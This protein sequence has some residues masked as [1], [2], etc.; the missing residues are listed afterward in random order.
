M[1]GVSSGDAV[2]VTTEGVAVLS[3]SEASARDVAIEDALRRAVEQ[4]VGTVIT[5]ESMTENYELLSDRIYSKATGHVRKYKILRESKDD[6]LFR[7]KIHA[8]VGTDRIKDDLEAI[9][10]LM[11]RKHKPRVMVIAVETIKDK[12]LRDL[13]NL[14]VTESAMI[15]IFRQKGFKV[16]DADTVKKVTERDQLLSALQGDN[17]LAAKIGLQ[18]GAEI[19]VMGK[20]TADSS[21]YIMSN[22]KLQSINANVTARVIRTDNAEIIATG[23]QMSTRAHISVISGAHTAFKIAGEK[24]AGTMVEQIL[25]KWTT[26][27]ANLNSVVL[28]I[29]GLDSYS[30]LI[31][32]KEALAHDVRGVKGVH[33]RS[34][35]GGEAKLEIELRGDTQALAEVLV[36]QEIGNLSIDITDMSQ[37]KIQ[38]R[39]ME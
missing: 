1:C 2:E 5:S 34:F 8:T 10:L 25:G 18:Y 24:L 6:G 11:Q 22:N 36:T 13:G 28:V 7:V 35:T 23:D 33:Q 3:S 4:A 27:T 16:I 29:S 12:Y 37:N 20:A 21:G 9:G 39:I 30:D 14:S 26:E 38:A 15:G 19:V 17:M 31:A 32:L